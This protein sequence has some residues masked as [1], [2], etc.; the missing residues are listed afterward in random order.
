MTPGRA[1][2]DGAWKAQPFALGIPSMTTKKADV[3]PMMKIFIC[4]NCGRLTA[5][6]RKKEVNCFKCGGSP[7]ERAKLT[8]EAYT[9]MDDRQRKDYS[10][11]WLYI[12]AAGKR[13][14]HDTF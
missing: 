10:D 9:E 6:S 14:R 3:K 7:M 13:K 11:S 1:P 12:R 2:G 5:V 4:P 8:F